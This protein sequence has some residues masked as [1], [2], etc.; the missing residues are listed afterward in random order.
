M[1]RAIALLAQKPLVKLVSVIR[2]KASI[3][4]GLNRTR[5]ELTKLKGELLARDCLF[6]IFSQSCCMAKFSVSI[7]T[8]YTSEVTYMYNETSSQ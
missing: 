8:K 1:V 7:P 3:I 4:A 5:P 2:G 6:I